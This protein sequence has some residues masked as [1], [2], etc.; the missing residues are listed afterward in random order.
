MLDPTSIR[1]RF[2]TFVPR[3]IVAGVT[4]VLISLCLCF[5]GDLQT[6]H[7]DGITYAIHF[8]GED[9]L[10]VFAAAL[11]AVIGC[12]LRASRWLEGEQAREKA[13]ASPGLERPT[14]L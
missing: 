7:T 6:S 8:S 5:L 13:T 4:G 11:T 3:V 12:S 10:M 9:H 14:S 2:G 1:R